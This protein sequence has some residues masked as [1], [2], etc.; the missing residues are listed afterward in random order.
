MG[1]CRRCGRE[2]HVGFVATRI[3]GT[4]G[5]SLETTKWAQVFAEEGCACAF[6][7][8]ELETPAGTSQMVP[9]AHFQHP[10]V[11]ELYRSCF[12][13]ER[14]RRE[15]TRRLHEAC[16]RLKAELY[17]FVE[18]FAV[19]LLVVENALTIPLNLPLGMAL[20]ELIS[21][22]ALPTIA[23]H[24][25][26]FWE[27]QHFLTNAAWEILNMA[28]PPNLPSIQHVVINSPAGHQLAL[29][30]GIAAALIPNVM[31]FH[32]PPPPPDDYAADVRRS[33]GLAEGELLVLQPTRVVKRKG[34]EHAV[35]L[36]RRLGRPARLVI[37]HASGDEG[38]DY[39]RRV[40]EY[41]QLM[42]VK[43]L[44][45]SDIIDE[46]R[47]RTPDGRKVYALEDIYP[48]ADLVTYP[49]TYEGFGNAFLEAVY[50][51]KPI[52]V[53]TYS[54]YQMDIRP[55]GFEVIEIDGYVSDDALERTRRV[56]DDPA[57]REAMVERNYAIA[58]R[59][60]SFD[61]LRRKLR[62]LLGD[63]RVCG[64][65]GEVPCREGA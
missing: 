26:F 48:H 49:S 7:G 13:V 14:R 61:V 27:R 45:V 22:T 9:E 53:N 42:G 28:F 4:D 47:G 58:R 33:L 2:H 35:E 60:F 20:A 50:F 43:T 25:D 51:R 19:D 59:C 65:E 56:L 16:V 41:A 21:E 12:G 18:R 8:G 30:T 34:I 36:V 44:F 29:R 63:G 5:V 54:I 62:N 1:A 11:R 6:F 10:E 37:S 39:E 38:H 40:R 32:H 57:H 24:H 52:L 17:R 46:R 64:L 3:A 15:A 55:K 31:D 23:H